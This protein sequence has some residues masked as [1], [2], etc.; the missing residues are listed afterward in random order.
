M[1]PIGNM[2]MQSPQELG[3]TVREVRRFRGLRQAELALAAGT[4]RRFVVDLEAGK[5]TVRLGE[6]LRV[7][8]ALDLDLSVEPGGE[9]REAA[10]RR[11][12]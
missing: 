9:A 3:A 2:K 11:L 6:V 1:F 4:G 7:L 10:W 5:S 8:R 12:S